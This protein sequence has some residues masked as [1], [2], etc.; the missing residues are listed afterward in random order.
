[1]KTIQRTLVRLSLLL[2]LPAGNMVALSGC[3]GKKNLGDRVENTAD[4]AGEAIEKAGEKA[5]NAV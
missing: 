3:D 4:K 1:M 5:E 2:I